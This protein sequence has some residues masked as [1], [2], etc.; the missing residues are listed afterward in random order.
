MVQLSSR[1]I[2][3]ARVRFLLW[4]M[5]LTSFHKQPLLGIAVNRHWIYPDISA[6]AQLLEVLTPHDGMFAIA[7]AWVVTLDAKAP[8]LKNVKRNKRKGLR[9]AIVAQYPPHKQ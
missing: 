9:V 2:D 4:H 8:A 6:I 1:H 5:Q 3:M 7:E